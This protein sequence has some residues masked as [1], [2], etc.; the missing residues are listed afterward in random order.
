MNL[1]NFLV[2]N[3]ILFVRQCHCQVWVVLTNNVLDHNCH[4]ISLIYMM[5]GAIHFSHQ[6]F[7]HHALLLLFNVW[8]E[9]FNVVK[10]GLMR[11]DW[12]IFNCDE[13]VFSSDVELVLNY[14]SMNFSHLASV[15]VACNVEDQGRLENCAV[16]IA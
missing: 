5:E 16:T 1:D 3:F 4:L 2:V 9:L 11:T 7:H 6:F 10:I 14:F 15:W 13:F 12:T 8:L